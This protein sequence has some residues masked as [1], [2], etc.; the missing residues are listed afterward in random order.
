M[1]SKIRFI[2]WALVGVAA[3]AGIW[4]ALKPPAELPGSAEMP[5]DTIGGIELVTRIGVP[6]GTG[7]CRSMTSWFI[8]LTQPDDT[9]LPMVHHSGE[10]WI[11]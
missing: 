8:I 2:L 10:P 11:R 1:L 5:L 4:I 3:L 9:D 6:F 7:S